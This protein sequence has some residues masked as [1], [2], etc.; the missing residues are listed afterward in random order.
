ME[1]IWGHGV[2]I[3]SLQVWPL[4]GWSP[5]GSWPYNLGF[6]RARIQSRV[7]AI[8]AGACLLNFFFMDRLARTYLQDSLTI[9]NEE[10]KALGTAAP[11]VKDLEGKAQNSFSNTPNIMQIPSQHES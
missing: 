8:P 1:T 9:R 3:Y 4:S 10:G 5:I 11:D 7:S 2:H 6:E